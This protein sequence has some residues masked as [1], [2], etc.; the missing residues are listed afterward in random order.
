MA[1]AA[2]RLGG[3]VGALLALAGAAQAA[4]ADVAVIDLKL[5]GGGVQRIWY[6]QPEH[7]VAAVVLFTGGDGVLSIDDA[8]TIRRDGNFLVRT[9]E[10]WVAHGFAVA[11]P[12]APGGTTLTSRLSRTNQEILARIVEAVHA[13]SGAP[14]WL[15]GTSRGTIS[16]AGGAGRLTAGEIAGVVLTSSVTRPSRSSGE[17]V[18]GADLERVSVPVLVVSHAGDRCAVTPASD[19]ERIRR[20]LPKSPKTEVMLFEGGLPPKSNECEAF[21]E[22]GYYGIEARVVD[23]ISDWIKAQTKP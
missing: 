16:A 22:H 7:P 15:V 11:V 9:R 5:S 17:T 13:R 3:L 14:V 12:D 4:A 6:R 10:Q 20:A 18:F 2:R 23:R 21:A 1:R 8:G 19:A